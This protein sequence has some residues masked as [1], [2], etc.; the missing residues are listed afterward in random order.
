MWSLI[1]SAN[2]WKTKFPNT[3]FLGST[4]TILGTVYQ[5][6]GVTPQSAAW[7]TLCPGGPSTVTKTDGT[8]SLYD[9]PIDRYRILAK[10]PAG[11]LEDFEQI[12][13]ERDST[14]SVTLTL[15]QPYVGC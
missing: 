14:T 15:N 1:R 4:G 5:A 8:F 3:I 11:T 10:N 9:I 12:T 6:D 2:Y 13:V 7:V